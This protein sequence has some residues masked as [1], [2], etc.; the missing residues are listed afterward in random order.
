MENAR[1]HILLEDVDTKKVTVPHQ[2]L[3]FLY[4]QGIVPTFKSLGETV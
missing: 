4:V 2:P 3:Q 1:G